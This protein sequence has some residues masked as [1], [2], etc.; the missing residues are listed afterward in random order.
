MKWGSK[1]GADY[2]NKLYNGVK[3]CYKGTSFD[4][5]CITE[6]KNDLN[7]HIKTIDLNCDF[8]GWM[9]K[10][11]LFSKSITKNFGR[12]VCFIDLD[13]IIYQDISYLGQYEG[14][15]CLMSTNDIQCENSKGGYNSSIILWRNG[16]CDN[17]YGFLENYHQHITKQ[18]IRFDH[19]LEFIVKNSDFVQT[20]FPG[21]VLD[22]NTYCKDKQDLPITG[23]I[24]AFPRYP[25]PHE[26]KEVWVEKYWI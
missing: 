4:F 3:R 5:W 18:V 26:C 9:K 14:D 23:S 6:N 22:Y 16:I 25:K 10:A 15:F 7:E 12:K 8:K 24:I 17:I 1:Y 11:Y 20:E 13:M 2:V 19:Y 21:Q